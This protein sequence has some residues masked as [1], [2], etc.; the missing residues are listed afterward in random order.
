[1]D[2]N[3]CW[4]EICELLSLPY[5]DKVDKQD[6]IDHLKNLAKWIEYGG[7]IPKI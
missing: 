1:M 6:L 3:A 7:F 2:P 4:K 5:L